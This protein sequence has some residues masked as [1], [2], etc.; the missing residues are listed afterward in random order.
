MMSTFL[1]AFSRTALRAS[2]IVVTQYG[3][4]VRPGSGAVM[5]RPAVKN[6]AAGDPR[7]PSARAPGTTPRSCP[8]RG[9]ARRRRRSRRAAQVVDQRFPRLAEMRVRID[10][11]RHH[12]LAGEVHARGASGDAD[13]AARPTCVNRPPLT[14]NEAF[15]IGARPSPTMTRAP[16]NTV[17]AGACPRIDSGDKA[18]AARTTNVARCIRASASGELYTKRS[19]RSS[20]V[21]RFQGCSYSRRTPL[22]NASQR[23]HG[24]AKHRWADV[25]TV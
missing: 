2:A 5:P 7:P 12:G 3:A 16:S 4:V 10:D 6:R 1:A 13:V 20:V 24:R 22:V 11:R 18:T 9:S 23:G 17:T 14:M 19:A 15:S 8:G 21:L 25:S